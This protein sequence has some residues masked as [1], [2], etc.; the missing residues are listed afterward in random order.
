METEGLTRKA[1]LRSA[2][3]TA[4]KEKEE[5]LKNYNG[6]FTA[7][8]TFDEKGKYGVICL[9]KMDGQKRLVKFCYMYDDP[10]S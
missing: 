6:I 7:N 5:D 8:F 2:E 10:Q 3:R 4:P 9:F 1:K